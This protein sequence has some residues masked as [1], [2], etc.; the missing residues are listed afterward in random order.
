M[1]GEVLV[2]CEMLISQAIFALRLIG[3]KRKLVKVTVHKKR[4][5][6]ILPGNHPVPIHLLKRKDGEFVPIKL[7]S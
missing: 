5:I 3:N 6:G 7:K 4:D 1:P 2:P